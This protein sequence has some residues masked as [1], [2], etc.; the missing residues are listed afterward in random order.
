MKQTTIEKQ[1]TIRLR[2]AVARNPFVRMAAPVTA[3]FGADEHIAIVGPNGAGK[4]LL[5]DM[6]TGKH[7]LREGTLDYDFRRE[8]LK[9]LLSA[10][11]E[12]QKPLCEALW[13]DL[14]KSEQEAILTELSIVEGEVKNHLKHLK[15]WMKSESRPTPLKMFPSRSRIV[16]EPLGQS[17]IIAPGTTPCSCCST[18]WWVG[19]RQ[20]VG[21]F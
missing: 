4:S 21:Q 20:D 10:L 8:Q 14:H 18:R 19:Y 11:R 17:L 6:L 2:D 7:L 5:V 15:K 12:W 1:Y 16:S 3:E 9:R 13:H